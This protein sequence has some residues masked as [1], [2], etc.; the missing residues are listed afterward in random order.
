MTPTRI[1][2]L[3]ENCRKESKGALIAYLT[4][5]DPAPEQTPELVAAMVRRRR[6]PD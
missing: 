4:A 2:R 3:F 5:G 1:S 6:G